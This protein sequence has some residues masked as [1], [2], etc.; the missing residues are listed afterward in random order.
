VPQRIE[1][2]GLEVLIGNWTAVP[3]TLHWTNS[4]QVWLSYGRRTSG[5]RMFCSV[6]AT[7]NFSDRLE[8]RRHL[9]L[10]ALSV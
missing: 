6:F 10:G 1:V 9:S 7:L 8:D 3:M 2:G 4:V 5:L